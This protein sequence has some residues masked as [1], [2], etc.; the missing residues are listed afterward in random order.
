MII[1][2]LPEHNFFKV[3]DLKTSW[4]QARLKQL[5]PIDRQKIIKKMCQQIS[6]RVSQVTLRHDASR[7][8]QC[9]LQFG[10]LEERFRILEDILKTAVDVRLFFTCLISLV[11]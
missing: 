8:V 10:S 7:V 4:N 6:G 9:I 11:T 3:E 2:L 5:G 1:F